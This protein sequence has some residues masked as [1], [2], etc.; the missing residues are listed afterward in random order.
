MYQ[1][2][3]FNLLLHDTQELEN[4]LHT[5]IVRRKTLHEWP[6]SCVELIES[7]DGDRWIYKSQWG[8]T[9]E[10]DFYAQAK[11]A[12]LLPARTLHRSESGHLNM[13]IDHLDAPTL[14]DLDLTEAEILAAG[15][16]L[17][18]KIARIEGPYP[19]YLDLS[20]GSLPGDHRQSEFVGIGISQFSRWEALM[21]KTLDALTGLI[22]REV[23][24]IVNHGVI[25]H[26]K[27]WVYSQEIQGALTG[28]TGLVH[29]DLCGENVLVSPDGYRVIDWQRPLLGPRELDLAV[30]LESMGIDPLRF[31]EKGVVWLMHLLRIAW[32]TDAAVRWFPEGCDSY[33]SEI[34]RLAS[35]VGNPI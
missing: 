8:P 16:D 17:L 31:I 6:L 35:L 18:E 14:S 26:L 12:L 34:A 5:P 21:G 22:H 20:R 19:C 13:L 33:D 27:K 2:P 15:Y 32:F 28:N 9:V 3:Y 29:N 7:R 24:K 25:A 1:H 23:F 4:L 11:S 30:L 10:A